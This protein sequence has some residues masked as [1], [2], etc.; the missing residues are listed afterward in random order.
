MILTVN[1]GN[2][3]ITVGGYEQDA[4]GHSAGGSTPTLPATVDEYAIRSGQPAFAL[5][6]LPR[7]DRG[8]HSG[9]RGA[10]ADRAGAGGSADAL[11]RPHP[12]RG[13]RPQERHQAAAGQPR[14]AG[15]RASLRRGGRAGGVPRPAGRHLGGYR[16]LHHGRQQQ[17]GAGGRR[18]PARAAA[19]ASAALVQ[20]TAQLPQ[21]DLSAPA[22]S[23][24]SG[25]EHLLLPA[26]W[27]RAGHRQPAG[28]A[29]RPLLR[30]AG[31][32]N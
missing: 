19:L 7:P 4:P 2:T 27:F 15:G 10:R 8:R 1:I 29:G 12:D 11:Q 30:R 22:P 17:T 31:S 23:I 6:C 26:E 3:H 20:K 14:P 16:H 25:K 13:A 32:R 24:C 28:W 21:I 5:P 9:Q 18:H